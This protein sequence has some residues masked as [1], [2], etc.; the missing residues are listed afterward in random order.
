MA[1]TR[2][3]ELICTEGQ[4]NAKPN[5]ILRD[6]EVIRVRK[7]NGSVSEKMGD[8]V[9]RLIDLPYLNESER[10][11]AA[12]D[13]AEGAS[14]IA[15]VAADRAEAVVAT[16]T[17]QTNPRALLREICWYDK[18]KGKDVF[19]EDVYTFC[20]VN[21]KRS[22]YTYGLEAHSTTS[23][24]QDIYV[25][26]DGGETW[27]KH[28]TLEIDAP[29]GIWY[30]DIFVDGRLS[31]LHVIKTTDGFTQSNNQL[32]SFLWNGENWW[33][34]G[35]LAL[36]AKKWLSNNNSIE[37]CTNADWSKR[38][39]IFGEYGTTTDGTPY[40]LYKSIDSG[41]T[42]TKVLELGG[43]SNGS[44]NTGEI[45]HWHTVQVDPYTLHWWAAAGDDD[46]Q[47]RIYRSTDDGDTWELMFSGTQRER[48]CGFVFEEDCIYYGMDSTNNWDENSIKI[49]KIDKS[50]LGVPGWS[51]ED[52]REDVAVVNGAFAV[53]GLSKVFYPEGFIVWSQREFG[54]FVKDKYVL[55]F[56][57]YAT[58][59][60]Y[61]IAQFDISH[62]PETTFAGFLAGARYQ[63]RFSGA[64][65]ARPSPC[66]HQAKYISY[67]HTSTHVKINVTC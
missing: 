60:I 43:N 19:F 12:A 29:N 9:T 26:R 25:S 45:R 23:T 33:P 14:D 1:Y 2:R 39:I 5:V 32:C 35:T 10:A 62:V 4:M 63:S 66:L 51:D 37:V 58:K 47:C 28:G 30:T 20:D 3:Q 56:Y 50:R 65:I 46:P 22:G 40:A 64:V 24:T 41:A 38:I 53:Y 44:V 21:G 61:P 49:V 52:I 42:W 13:R 17:H 7:S 67:D 27:E 59:N 55:E 54:S 11:E 57:D 36:G 18:D 6:G 48:T 16:V 8:G 31:T 34:T 15:R